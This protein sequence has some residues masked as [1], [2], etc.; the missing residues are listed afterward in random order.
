MTYDELKGLEVSTGGTIPLLADVFTVCKNKTWVNIE[1]KEENPRAIEPVVR[2]VMDMGMMDQVVFSSFVHNLRPELTKVLKRLGIEKKF[3]F[4]YLV[5]KFEEFPNYEQ[6]QEGDSLNIDY[7]L[8]LKDS[9]RVLDE[10]AKARA[11]GM[12]IKFYIP[13]PH[14]IDTE[15][16]YKTF[17]SLDVDTV[18]TDFPEKMLEYFERKANKKELKMPSPL[19]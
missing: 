11:K 12:L 6:A 10:I 17:E 5:W 7:D 14:H 3:S 2:L 16:D 8:Y 13:R 1:L 19:N 15:E 18:I 9:N 4:G